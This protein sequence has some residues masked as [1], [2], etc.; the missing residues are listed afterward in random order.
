M[1]TQEVKRK[2]TA[3]LSA[4][5]KGYSRLMEEDEEGTL[6]TLT[7]YREVMASLIRQHNGRVVNAPGDALL[8]EFDSVVDAVKSAAEIQR[9]LAKRNADL[10]ADQRMEYR[11]GINLGDVMVDGDSIYGDGVNIA[12]RLESL[13][14]AGGICISGTAFDHVKN[15]LNLG[16]KYLGEQAVKNILE[17]VRVYQVL[18]EPEAAGK[19]IGEKK[20]KPRQ[21]QRVALSL[22]VI[23]IVIVAA[24]VAY[25]NLRPSA[26]R[27][28]VASK[29]KM[30]FPLPDKPSIAVLPFTNMSNDKE[31]DYFADGLAEEIINA[32]SKLS[33]VFVI[34]RNSSFTYKGR[35]VKVQQVAE[36][37]GVRYV[38][39]GGVRK[40][41]DK[42]R[43]TA[44]LVDALSGNYLMSEQYERDIKDIFAIQDDVTMK[45]L[46]SLRVNLTEGESA[47][48]F[49]RGTKNLEAY[50][51]LLQ[52][53]E[54]RMTWNKDSLAR[55]RQLAEEA[56]TLDPGYALA[57]SQLAWALVSEVVL[58]VYDNP[59]KVLER[60]YR[61]AERAVALD[62]SLAWSHIA[63]GIVIARYKKD[64]D[65]AVAEGQRAIALEPGSAYGYGFL[66]IFLTWA[67]R[68]EDAIP[69]YR[70]AF[71]LSPR[72]LPVWSFNLTASYIAMGQYEEAIK[73][74]KGIVEKQPDQMFAHIYLAV[75]YVLS[76]REDDARKEAAEILR[77]DPTFS[78]ERHFSNSPH[79]D[80]AE[81]GRRKEA[82]RKA[83]LK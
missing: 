8:A 75:A 45:V 76:G 63:L 44:Q 78:V 65:K 30:A 23:L 46:T 72:P 2:L 14:D 28:E 49:A 52:A 70:K 11:I 6:R 73:I 38:L 48:A 1:T 42:V 81:V 39:E 64:W 61:L 82:L 31:Q 40:M 59:Q 18:M 35:Q 32:L 10:P 58:G 26:P 19:V 34:A 21:W 22:G 66:A 9:E 27:V 51:K 12:A 29:E 47:R 67:G 68:D 20:T 79:K 60:A 43:I 77:I 4:D 57:Y 41:G 62:D 36:E 16:Y 50:L 80:Q 55:A 69:Y 53:Y 7:T 83:G 54:Q 17:P 71:R 74:L 3:I 15:K 56:V 5:V 24:V 33:N 37:M 13:A 25:F